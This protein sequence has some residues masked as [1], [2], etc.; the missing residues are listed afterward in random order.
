M[1]DEDIFVLTGLLREDDL[2]AA[3]NRL[4]EQ[5]LNPSGTVVKGVTR[6]YSPLGVLSP[7]RMA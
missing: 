2:D 6:A 4:Q 7:L 5:V 1:S 3:G